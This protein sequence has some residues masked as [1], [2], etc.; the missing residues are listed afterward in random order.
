MKEDNTS[1]DLVMA[2]NKAIKIGFQMIEKNPSDRYKK[3]DPALW[4]PN[5][6][7]L[8]G[9]TLVEICLVVTFPTQQNLT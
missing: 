4:S 9:I 5:Q 1:I 7:W 8:K 3:S 2:Q 6:I